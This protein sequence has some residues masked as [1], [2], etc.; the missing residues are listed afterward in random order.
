MLVHVSSHVPIET[1]SSESTHNK[2][3][4]G[5]KITC[6]EVREKSYGDRNLYNFC[7]V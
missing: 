6:T 7:V 4:Y 2:Q 5:C 1:L 3:Q